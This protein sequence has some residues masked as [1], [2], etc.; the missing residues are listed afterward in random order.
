MKR[1]RNRLTNL[2]LVVF[3]LSVLLFSFSFSAYRALS[4]QGKLEGLASESGI[5]SYL[6]NQITSQGKNTLKVSGLVASL[7]SQIESD[8]KASYS[9][10]E[11]SDQSNAVISSSYSW[12][13]G[14]A[15]VPNFNLDLSDVKQNL[16]NDI[17]QSFITYVG[18]LPDCSFA[19][20]VAIAKSDTFNF[21]CK[22]LGFNS[23]YVTSRILADLSSGNSFLNN[24]VVTA[25]TLTINHK[26]YYIQ[27]S[28][29]PS[30]YQLIS[31]LP[32]IAFGVM[33]ICL[34][35]MSF[36]SLNRRRTVRQIGI[37]LIIAGAI[38]LLSVLVKGSVT[39]HITS[40]LEG[41]NSLGELIDPITYIIKNIVNTSFK[42]IE[43]ISVIYIFLGLV[44]VYFATGTLPEHVLEP[45]KPR[46]KKQKAMP[47]E[48]P[49]EQYEEELPSPELPEVVIRP[50][51]PVPRTVVKPKPVVIVEPPA[52]IELP[53][54]PVKKR[55][56]KKKKPTSTNNKPPVRPAPRRGMI[57]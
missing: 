15:S 41:S 8:T 55:K 2:L 36:I 25:Q 3:F 10:A 9:Q 22:P 40:S 24:A 30:Y 42:F 38:T 49:E 43:D 46:V 23:T 39:N 6:I 5:Y 31:K 7:S 50:P 17:A 1:E 18:A 54:A 21:V 19:Q 52:P 37:L 11:F 51:I 26:P 29:L 4:N 45:V 33:V 28:K 48:V 20:D 44:C 47:I 14:K 57:Q 13:K 12:L 56:R 32:Y 27:Y 34:I 53:P 35:L 16:F